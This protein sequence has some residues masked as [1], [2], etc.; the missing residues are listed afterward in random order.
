M[1]GQKRTLPDSRSNQSHPL[2]YTRLGGI[3]LCTQLVQEGWV[4]K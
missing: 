2:E 1:P 3:E 4:L